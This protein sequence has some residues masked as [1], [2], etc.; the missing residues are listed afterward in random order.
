VAGGG[1]AASGANETV[2]SFD[3]P[4]R[5]ISLFP[6]KSGGDKGKDNHALKIRPFGRP[7]L[8]P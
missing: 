3:N 8:K 2:N 1:A 4:R 6:P 7:K 5:F